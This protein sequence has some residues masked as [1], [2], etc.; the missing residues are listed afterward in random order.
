VRITVEEEWLDIAHYPCLLVRQ[1]N[2][3]GERDA[4]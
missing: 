1:V 4:V 2:K 3:F